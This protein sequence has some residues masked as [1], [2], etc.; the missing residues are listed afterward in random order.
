MKEISS[1]IKHLFIMI[2]E[3]TRDD[4]GVEFLN[5]ISQML[6][7]KYKLA[8]TQSGFNTKIIVADASIV[9]KNVIAQHLSNPSPEPNKIYFRLA[10]SEA[11]LPLY[12]E[13]FKFKGLSA[14]AINTNSYPASSLSLTYKVIVESAKFNEAERLKQNTKLVETIQSGILEDI[15]TLLQRS[16]AIQIIVYIHNKLLLADLIEKIRKHR[17][18]FEKYQEYL[19]IH[20]NISEQEK[21]LINQYKNDVKIVFMTASGSRGLSFPKTKHILVE[22]P[23]FKIEKN[24]M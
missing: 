20:A 9:D 22:I 16:D 15:E 5:N 21:S 12:V 8:D 6:F 3:I 2:D 24:L 23:R 14:T 17:G 4:G 19:E 11:I 10:S 18:E 13:Q 1:R 7:T